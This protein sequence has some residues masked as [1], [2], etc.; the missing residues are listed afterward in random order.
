MKSRSKLVLCL[1][2]AFGLAA[3]G[4]APAFAS[5]HREAPLAAADPQIDATDLYA[6]VSP[7]APDTVTLISNWIPFESPSGGPNF[8][9]WAENTK[10]DINIDNNGDAKPDIT[11]RWIFTSHYKNKDTFL[12][13]TGPVND[14]NDPNLNFTQ[15]YTLQRI[16]GGQTQTL[17][18]D[19]PVAPSDV[20]A[21]SMPDY[22]KLRDQAIVPFGGGKA[23][24]Y[25][26]QADDPFF[27][28]LRVFDLLYGANLKEAG[29]DTLDGFNVNVL[30]L[31]VPKTDLVAGGDATANPIFGTWTT[32]ERPSTTVLAA[33]GTKKSSGPDVQ[34]ARLGN[35]LVNE[36]V[37]PVQF[38]DYF[39]GSQPSGDAVFLPK[40]QDPE[41]PH[42][43][44]KVYK[45]PAPPTPRNDLVSVFLTGVDKLNKPPNVVPSE[46]L[47]LNTSIAPSSN[48]NRLGVIGGD[49]AGYPN[50][51]RLAD[52]II[53]IDLRVVEGV[54]TGAKGQAASLGDGVDANDVPFGTSFPYV[55]LPHSG[56][57][58][59]AKAA[60]AS[61]SGTPKGSAATGLGETRRTG[62]STP[63]LP[64]VAAGLGAALVAGGLVTRRRRTPATDPAPRDRA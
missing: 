32:A 7:D 34:V 40:V 38:K 33:D 41:L 53:D 16:A 22:K 63:V 61:T 18:S 29:A 26:G 50:G 27:L 8:Y 4:I 43:I 51:R 24:S 37:V 25:A 11:Y 59:K 6:F 58:A 48:P 64:W 52:D 12:Y 5:S 56:S 28:D 42:V 30:A 10:Y 39:N 23:K 19:A 35:P 17:L 20:G 45:I 36:V 55:A 9:P 21:A 49:N 57:D 60:S 44:E 46:E 54:L 47:R 1:A 14:L 13:N 31:Q 62:T 15:T 3:T 2:V